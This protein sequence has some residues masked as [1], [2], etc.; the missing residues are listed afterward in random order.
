MPV[1]VSVHSIT[2]VKA[3]AR[4]KTTEAGSRAKKRPFAP[5]VAAAKGAARVKTTEA[6]SRA[7][8]RSLAPAEVAAAEAAAMAAATARQ[9]GG[10]SERNNHRHDCKRRGDAIEL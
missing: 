1:N 2:W 4:V 9:R 10:S 8:K 3:A 5:G 6:G 7:E